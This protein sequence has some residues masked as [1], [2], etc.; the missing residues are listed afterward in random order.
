MFSR[1]WGHF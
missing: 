1:Y